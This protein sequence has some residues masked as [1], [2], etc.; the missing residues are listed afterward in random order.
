MPAG[1]LISVTSP[2]IFSPNET[3][4]CLSPGWDKWFCPVIVKNE[5]SKGA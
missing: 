4:R 5:G 3:L 1:S 2:V